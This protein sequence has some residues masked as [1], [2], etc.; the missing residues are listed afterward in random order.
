[1]I[2]KRDLR[3]ESFDPNKLLNSLST[4][5]AKRPLPVGKI[6]EMV[7]EIRNELSSTDVSEISSEIIGTIVMGKLKEIDRVAYIRF[8]S[9]YLDF[10]DPDQFKSEVESLDLNTA[11]SETNGQLS[12][13]DNLDEKNTTTKGLISVK[14]T[15]N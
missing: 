11:S 10:N 12:F 7:S 6:E 8:A 5:C 2:I 9:V 14:K 15:V 1:M 3:R 13:L 4:A